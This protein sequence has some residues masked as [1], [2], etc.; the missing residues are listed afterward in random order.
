MVAVARNGRRG[1]REVRGPE[2]GR[3]LSLTSTCRTGRRGAARRSVVARTWCSSP[4]TILLPCRRSRR[5]LLD[6]LVKTGGPGPSCAETVTRLQGRF[7]ALRSRRRNTGGCCTSSR[8][9][10]R[11]PESERLP[12]LWT[13]SLDSRA[14]RGDSALIP[15]DDVDYLR[16]DTKYT[17]SRGAT[18][19]ADPARR[20]S[21]PAQ[22]AALPARSRAVRAGAP[23]RSWSI[24]GPSASVARGQRNGRHPSEGSQGGAAPVSRSYLHLFRQM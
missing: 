13:A 21:A 15:V 17:L 12:R 3:L 22:G 2:A 1:D 19:P 11:R 9:G 4:P 18:M 24:C 10:S 23:D 14:G 6:Y 8:P 20:S 5:A 7:A 16:A